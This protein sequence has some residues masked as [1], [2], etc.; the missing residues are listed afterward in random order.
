MWIWNLILYWILYNSIFLHFLF[1]WSLR[2]FF[3]DVIKVFWI[4]TRRKL[5]HKERE[6]QDPFLFCITKGEFSLLYNVIVARGALNVWKHFNSPSMKLITQGRYFILAFVNVHH[7]Y[8]TEWKY[9]SGVML[10][11]NLTVTALK[12]HLRSLHHW[13]KIFFLLRKY[14]TVCEVLWKAYSIFVVNIAFFLKRETLTLRAKK[15]K[16][17]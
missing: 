11:Y 4:I 17:V 14:F 15:Y 12:Q 1:L 3:V 6:R 2:D 10:I 13:R 5:L 7:H 9:F 8:L 16:I